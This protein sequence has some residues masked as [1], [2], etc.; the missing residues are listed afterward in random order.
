MRAYKETI[1]ISVGGSLLVPDRVDVDFISRL[2]DMVRF[3]INDGYQIALIIGGGKTSRRYGEVASSF[4]HISNE[5]LDWI[6]IKSIHLNAELIKRCYGDLDIHPEVILKREDISK[7]TESLVI[8]GAWKPGHSSDYNAVTM[9]ESF[10]GKK[11]I[12]FSNISYVYDMDPVKYPDAKIIETLTW[13][14]YLTLI[15]TKWEANLSAPFDPVAS[16]KAQEL[17]MTVAILGSSLENLKNYLD[18]N[19]FEGSIIS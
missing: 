17:G 8:V 16:R 18:G 7:V 15:P 14:K 13:D 6:G 19:P 2:K 1:V 5:D 3:F 11:V 4:S 10:G 12:N 9:A